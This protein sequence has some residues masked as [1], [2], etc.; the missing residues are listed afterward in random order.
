M[1]TR[2]TKNTLILVADG[3]HA[4]MYRNISD[5]AIQIES[6]GPLL[7]QDHHLRG[8][9]NLPPETSPHEKHEAEFAKR[10]ATDLYRRAHEGDYEKLVIIADPQ[11]LGQIRPN[12]HAEV[13]G[14]IILE[15]HKTLTNSSIVDIEKILSVQSA[16]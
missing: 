6:M 10:I 8:P 11:T 3:E 9:A 12:L 2:I 1:T 15:L 16:A 14:R 4:I 7:S 5:T 13:T